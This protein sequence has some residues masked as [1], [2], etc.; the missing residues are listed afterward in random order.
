VGRPLRTD[1]T[2]KPTQWAAY[3]MSTC[4]KLVEMQNQ[5][6]LV[7]NHLGYH[8]LP[9]LNDL[10]PAVVTTNHNQVKDYCKDVYLAFG[11]LPFVSISDSYRRLNYPDQLNY[12]ATIYNGI[13]ID[14]FVSEGKHARDYLLFVGRLCQD[15]GTAEA[16]DIAKALNMPLK[17]AGKIDKNDEAYFNAQIKPRLSAY[18]KAEYVGEV[19]HDQKRKLY[20]GAKA[21]VYPINFDEP[22]GLVMAESLAAGTPLM[23]LDRG[24]V[25]EVITDKKTAI[26]GKSIDELIRRYPEI[27]KLKAEDCV[28]RVRLYF[29]VEHM[30]DAYEETYQLLI[31]EKDRAK[32]A[33]AR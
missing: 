32:S 20:A 7:H 21:V 12:V 27:D 29:S 15:K 13:D 23:A 5:F 8:A 31:E 30:V 4:L 2:R 9:F 22:F 25:R 19:N 1:P 6:D 18:E 24:S 17:I 14:A 28:E 33:L 10:K 3:D 26:I 11:H 16:L